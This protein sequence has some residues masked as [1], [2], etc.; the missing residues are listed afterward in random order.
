MASPAHILTAQALQLD[1]GERLQLAAELI[2]SVEG[3]E[4]SDWTDAWS[5]ELD[6]RS[7][8]ADAREARGEARGE[9]W[10]LVRERLV[11]QL[12]KG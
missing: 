12:A 2:D 10:T 9:S 5:E 4:D 1:P 6:R 8:G 3:V 7:A 11:S